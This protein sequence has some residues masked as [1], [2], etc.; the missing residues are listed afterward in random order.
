VH[1]FLWPYLE[2]PISAIGTK[3]RVLV[4]KGISSVW[5][6]RKLSTAMM[7]AKAC[8]VTTPSL[9]GYAAGTSV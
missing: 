4:E 8:V 5:L 7:Y 1:F 3:K 2:P 9:A 6:A